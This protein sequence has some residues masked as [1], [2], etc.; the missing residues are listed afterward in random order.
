MAQVAPK[1][2]IASNVTF[3]DNKNIDYKFED[4][5]GITHLGKTNISFSPNYIANLS[6]SFNANEK[7]SFGLQNQYVGSQYLDNTN[8]SDLKLND[9]FL[10]DFSA[11][12]G[13]KLNK[14]NVDFKFLLNN[15]FNQNY[16]NN[17]Y[18]YGSTPYYYSQ[19]GT[20]FMFGVT[21][22]MK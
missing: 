11:R 2:I 5:S 7:L 3:S 19:A 9:Y 12:Y 22:L 21:L 16:V 4:N 13:L 14:M 1:W 17:G 8:N 15:I 18:V 6:V 10:T 20:N